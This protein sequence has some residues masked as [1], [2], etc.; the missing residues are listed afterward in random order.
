M[1][2]SVKVTIEIHHF[3]NGNG[4][5]DRQTEFRTHSVHQC[6]FDGDCD[7]D[8]GGICK[9]TFRMQKSI[10]RRFKRNVELPSS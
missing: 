8:G 5:F 7:G 9:R 2:M 6:K 1:S 4:P 10:F 3:A